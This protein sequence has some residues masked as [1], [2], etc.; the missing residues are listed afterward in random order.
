MGDGILFVYIKYSRADYHRG[1]RRVTRNLYANV[2]ASRDKNKGLI[3]GIARIK[4]SARGINQCLAAICQL[5]QLIRLALTFHQFTSLMPAP[6]R[7][8]L[9][10]IVGTYARGE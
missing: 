3:V 10:I 5:N 4:R 8:C 7:N 2:L 9:F 6:T 1:F